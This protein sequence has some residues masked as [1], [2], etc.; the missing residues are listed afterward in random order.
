MYLHKLI[1]FLHIL[2][3]ITLFSF[4]KTNLKFYFRQLSGVPEF[5]ESFLL[6][7][8]KSN[9]GRYVYLARFKGSFP[10]IVSFKFLVRLVQVNVRKSPQG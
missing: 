5:R 1:F 9:L 2:T 8:P 6:L 10:F 4:Q 7:N 3:I